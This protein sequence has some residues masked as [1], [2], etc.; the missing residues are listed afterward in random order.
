MCKFA[1]AQEIEIVEAQR[2]LAIINAGSEQGLQKSDTLWVNDVSDKKDHL[3]AKALVIALRKKFAA[4]EA[5]QYFGDYRLANGQRVFRVKDVPAPLTA[6]PKI[7]RRAMQKPELTLAEVHRQL[8]RVFIFAGGIAPFGNMSD[9]FTGSFDAGLGVRVHVFTR[10]H[11]SLSGRYI[12]LRNSSTLNKSLDARG[13]QNTSSQAVLA[14]AVRP[15]MRYI[16]VEGGPALFATRTTT[17]GTGP[18]AKSTFFDGG[19]VVG[20]GRYFELNDHLAW[21]LQANLHTY[22]TNNGVNG[23]FDLNLQLHF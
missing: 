8:L 21:V 4:I 6:P 20:A 16:F 19:V 10:I 1:I 11:M 15:V 9:S 18:E 23:F 5:F 7:T 17:S 13:L 2:R 14:L 12:F 22:F 3:V